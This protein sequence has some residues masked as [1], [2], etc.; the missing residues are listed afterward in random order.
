MTEPELSAS[1]RALYDVFAA[2]DP[3]CRPTPFFWWSGGD[4]D[5]TRLAAQLTEL[6]S[7]GIGGTIVG[8]SHLPDGELDHGSPAPLTDEWWELFCW[9]TEESARWGMTV[10]F[11]DYGINGPILR[12]A[13]EQTREFGAGTLEHAVERR[14]G[15]ATYEIPAGGRAVVAVVGRDGSGSVQALAVTGPT[16]AVPPGEWEV[17]IVLKREGSIG[18]HRSSFDPMHPQSGA[19]LIELLY[20]PFRD[21]LGLHF[22]TTFTTFFQDELYFGLQMPLWNDLVAAHLRELHDFDHREWLPAL[23]LDLGPRTHLFR[24]A[25]R[26]TV[27]GLL[28]DHYFRPI[29]KWHERHGTSMFMDQIARG[30][31]RAGRHAY[32]DYL[33]MMR[34]YNG[35]G[36]DDPDLTAPRA[37]AAFKVSTSIAR[38]N[39]RPI[40][41]SEAFHSSGWGI[42]PAKILGG[43]N[44]GFG[45]G[46]N[47]VIMH[48][49]NHTTEGG[50]WEWASPDFHFRQPWWQHSEALWTYI[51]RI[52]AL[53]RYGTGVAE[54]AVLDPT[55]DLDLT[56][57]TTGSPEFA[58]KV[59]ATLAEAGHDSDLIDSHHLAQARTVDQ[60]LTVG[61]CAYRALVV[62]DL[63]AVRDETL[64][65]IRRYAEAGGTVIVLG[66]VP[67][68]TELGPCPAG[69]WNFALMLA[70]DDLPSMLRLL[71][72]RWEPD[73]DALGSGLVAS[74]RRS[75][76]TDL[77]F[78]TNVGDAAV[79][80]SID[81]R[82]QGRVET[83][84]AWT[85]S[86]RPR[87][88][89]PAPGKQVSTRLDID[90]APGSA[91]V[92][93]I[94]GSRPALPVSEP[95]A[96]D[97]TV[98][99]VGPWR[100]QVEPTLD[101]SFGD[102]EYGAEPLGVET[103]HLST[104]ASPEGP[105][106]STCA[107]DGVKFLALG[108]VPPSSVDEVEKLVLR[109]GP[110]AVVDSARWRPY[111][112]SYQTGVT[113]DPL[114]LDRMTGPHGLK[115]VPDE[116]LDP[117]VLDSDAPAG[118]V[119][120][121]WSTI[122]VG[123]AAEVLT[124]AAGS[125]SPYRVWIDGEP[126]LSRT[127]EV[128]PRRTPAWNLRDLSVETQLSEVSLIPGRHSVLLRLE[129]SG[130]QPTRAFVAVGTD[131]PQEPPRAR[132]RWWF[133]N[134][135]CLTF[136][137]LPNA[138]PV[139]IRT[140]TPPG[141]QAAELRTAGTI[142][143]ATL[144]SSHEAMSIDSN[145]RGRSVIR[146]SGLVESRDELLIEVD[147]GT[148]GYRGAA[149]LTGPITWTLGPGSASTASFVDHGLHD[150]SGIVRYQTDFDWQTTDETVQ[151]SIPGLESSARIHV[152]GQ[153]LADLPT[154]WQEVDITAGL[155]D[156]R[157]TVEVEVAN[158]LQN[159]F[160]ILPS[161][162][163]KMQQAGGGF[164]CLRLR[165]VRR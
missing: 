99:L 106:T 159:R 81:V 29:F 68:L 79:E 115:N 134:Q 130:G 48:G 7:K 116:F 1:M 163:T 143:T 96:S 24:A 91:T 9:F 97:R 61:N 19:L 30:D 110:R 113:G 39:D 66:D 12:R 147:R 70:A 38:L 93:V 89:R 75:G 8:Y 154:P 102:F 11:Q 155:R 88:S 157:N 133:G 34:W 16:Y 73:F 10:G 123:N 136:D 85:G 44:A 3:A 149:V 109:D 23:W 77:Y 33:Q 71:S 103:W 32:G 74:H 20:Q 164:T 25:Y 111:S 104:S 57:E 76:T 124:V 108:P 42:P 78:I 92:V 135:P 59:L 162:F 95:A 129:V 165:A 53:L 158:T 117:Q 14:T 36:N 161:P 46:V 56:G 105:W 114:L 72:S 128:A 22:G 84:D 45:Y 21:R 120:Y 54:V 17:S 41:P 145:D 139:W 51:T 13:G 4:V 141:F 62:P 94:D 131:I 40:V 144:V 35:P 28:E 151:L 49:L 2:P 86:I 90:L 64:R 121:F 15:P 37:V 67:T 150:F 122:E 63:H 55:Q 5:R 69:S 87:D 127:A 148:F 47:Q 125:R 6:A 107:R 98:E 50:W 126:S 31:L 100:L 27:V 52:S 140:L 58:V 156:G 82:A 80:A 83:F 153:P 137:P 60:R 138:Q 26:D 43:L 101:N 65:A 132:L 152:N 118:S 18:S 142:R 119:Y 160:S 112:F 146:A